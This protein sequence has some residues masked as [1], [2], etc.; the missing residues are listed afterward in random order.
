VELVE[1]QQVLLPTPGAAELMVEEACF[2]IEKLLVQP[3]WVA[4]SQLMLVGGVSQLTHHEDSSWNHSA[5][6][7]EC[8]IFLNPKQNRSEKCQR[9]EIVVSNP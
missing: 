1:V 5:A 2:P 7:P 6:Y 9:D 4:Q 3:V 8:H